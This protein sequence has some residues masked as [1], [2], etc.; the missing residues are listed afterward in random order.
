[1]DKLVPIDAQ[2][3]LSETEARCEGEQQ[4]GYQLKSIKF[5]TIVDAGNVFPVNKAEFDFASSVEILNDLTFVAIGEHQPAEIMAQMKSGGMTFICE[6]QIYIRD[7]VTG[8]MVFGKH[9]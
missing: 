1:M 7:H 3:T 9:T 8:I 2:L 5:G 6:T 4:T